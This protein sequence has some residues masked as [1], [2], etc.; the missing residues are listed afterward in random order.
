MKNDFFRKKSLR[1]QGLSG[2]SIVS[3]I[4]SQIGSHIKISQE[5]APTQTH[6][7]TAEVGGLHEAHNVI[8]R[9][10]LNQF[11]SNF[12][13]SLYICHKKSTNHE[14]S[15]FTRLGLFGG[16]LKKRRRALAGPKT[17]L[18]QRF[19]LRAIV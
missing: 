5:C 4:F 14:K 3:Q 7:H 12:E 2:I 10:K 8:T 18:A 13:H 16:K 17:N 15:Q 6:R 9:L 1:P 19:A 11:C